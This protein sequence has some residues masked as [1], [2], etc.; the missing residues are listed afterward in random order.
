MFSEES[1]ELEKD[2]FAVYI[3]DYPGIINP[4]PNESERE[5]AYLNAY[6]EQLGHTTKRDDVTSSKIMGEVVYPTDTSNIEDCMVLLDV[7]QIYHVIDKHKEKVNE[8]I[9]FLVKWFIKDFMMRTN[10]RPFPLKLDTREEIVFD[11]FMLVQKNN[12]FQEICTTTIWKM[13]AIDLGFNFNA[14]MNLKV[15]LDS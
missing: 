3:S 4:D 2:I 11:L 9:M 6:H 14:E 1:K 15:I 7:L 10:G 13:M 12:V 5:K 8:E